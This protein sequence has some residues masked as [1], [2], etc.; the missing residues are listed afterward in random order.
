MVRIDDTHAYHGWNWVRGH[1]LSMDK[2]TT[3]GMIGS[4]VFKV[5]LPT[6]SGRQI[7]EFSPARPRPEPS[8]PSLR[9]DPKEAKQRLRPEA[10]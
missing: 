1:F 10:K 6:A 2:G 9:P 5:E 8:S 4:Q 3:R 7:A